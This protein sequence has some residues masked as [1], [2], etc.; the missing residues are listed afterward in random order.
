MT[1][2]LRRRSDSEPSD[3]RPLRAMIIDDS[4]AYRAY[5]SN[6]VARFGFT[7]RARKDGQEALEALSERARARTGSVTQ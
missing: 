7:V 4:E 6:L 1:T 5:I 2:P 3:P